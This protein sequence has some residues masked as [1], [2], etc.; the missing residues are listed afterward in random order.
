MRRVN[1][2]VIVALI[3]GLLTNAHSQTPKSKNHKPESR[4]ETATAKR[5]VLV[6][7][8]PASVEGVSLKDGQVK[9]K[10][11]YKF[12]KEPNNTIT[13][14]RMNGAGIGGTWKCECSDKGACGV[15][16][17]PNTGLDCLTESCTGSCTLKVTVGDKATAVLMSRSQSLIRQK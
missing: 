2:T 17:S 4:A 10:P 12:V 1:M 16:I 13:V 7:Q 3:L 11:G 8:L 9:L 6:K 15:S 5:T 14:A